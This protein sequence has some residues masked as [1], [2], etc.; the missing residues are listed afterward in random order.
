MKYSIGISKKNY[1]IL[2]REGR[3]ERNSGYSY[4][5]NNYNSQMGLDLKETTETLGIFEG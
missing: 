1:N 2:L 5:S 3:I 4:V